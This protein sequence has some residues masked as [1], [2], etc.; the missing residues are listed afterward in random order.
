MHA[1]AENK[2]AIANLVGKSLAKFGNVLI[3][4]AARLYDEFGSSAWR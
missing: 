3:E 2:N 4:F 1:A